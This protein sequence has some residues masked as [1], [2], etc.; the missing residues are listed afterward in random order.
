MYTCKEKQEKKHNKQNN[1]SLQKWSK[2]KKKY[3][4][5]K[6]SKKIMKT[7]KETEKEA[8]HQ[9]IIE[10]KGKRG[11]EQTERSKNCVKRGYIICKKTCD[12]KHYKIRNIEMV[13]KNN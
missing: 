7:K 3:N 10:H 1:R 9:S 2:R 6:C 13:R 5:R 12:N 8:Q 4:N 11:G